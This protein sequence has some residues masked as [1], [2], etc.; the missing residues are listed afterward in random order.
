MKPGEGRL[1]DA[2][3]LV[4]AQNSVHKQHQFHENLYSA[5]LRIK[6]KKYCKGNKKNYLQD[7][8]FN[9]NLSRPRSFNQFHK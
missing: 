9:F 4:V 7:V 2:L 3:Q 8:K 6:Y 5:H 1:L